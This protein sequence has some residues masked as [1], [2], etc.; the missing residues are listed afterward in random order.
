[1]KVD[2]GL[3]AVC[4]AKNSKF[5]QTCYKCGAALPWAPD[6]VAP[7]TPAA[8]APKPQSQPASPKPAS[9]KPAPKAAPA[10]SAKTV[11]SPPIDT[12]ALTPDQPAPAK[13]SVAQRAQKRVAIPAWAIGAGVLGC[14]AL[15]IGLK[16]LFS[17]NAAVPVATPA[18]TTALAPV[19][20]APT[21]T[22]APTVIP[23]VISTVTPTL[24]P[25]AALTPAPTSA[26]GVM[27]S[28]DV[29]PDFD[30]FYENSHQGTAAQQTLYWDAVKGKKIAWRGE[31]VSLG[32]APRGPL[33]VRCKSGDKTMEVSVNLD[34]GQN[35]PPYSA[36]Q[37]VS[38]EGVL[39][40]H[41]SDNVEVGT[42]R[43]R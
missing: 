16:S 18:P 19:V 42:G 40:A 37:S 15:G 1:M 30:T 26:A 32:A 39:S 31:F 41:T 35:P 17:K 2:L 20:V 7:Q 36:G 22:V 28:V 25:T 12:D 27:Q 34:E 8:P 14:I 6:Y 5:V 10:D 33:V 43:I 38:F 29:G 9:P 23:T 21:A 4:G 13:T 3:C 24:A 11:V